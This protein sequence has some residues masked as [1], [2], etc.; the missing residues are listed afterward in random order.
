MQRDAASGALLS[1]SKSET[2]PGKAELAGVVASPQEL[3]A[4][5]R[6]LR[7]PARER[8]LPVGR[9]VRVV[10]GRPYL[11][12]MTYSLQADGVVVFVGVCCYVL[13]SSPPGPSPT[14]ASWR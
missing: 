11:P 13:P 5:T 10:G 14:L 1:V 8:C 3:R 2:I 6:E 7:L 12:Y 9:F 4:S